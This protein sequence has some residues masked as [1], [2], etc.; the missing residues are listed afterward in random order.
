MSTTLLV[1]LISIAPTEI[2]EKI[3]KRVGQNTNWI[4]FAVE[5]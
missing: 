2:T 3:E 4:R 1:G 5:K